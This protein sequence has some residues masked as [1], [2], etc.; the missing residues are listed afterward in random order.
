[1]TMLIILVLL[2]LTAFGIVGNIV[3]LVWYVSKLVW[4][5]FSALFLGLNLG[6]E[7]RA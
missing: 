6:I 4:L 7:R 3:K 2:A 5:V 1:M